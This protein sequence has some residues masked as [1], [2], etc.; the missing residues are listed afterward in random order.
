MNEIDLDLIDD[1][2][3]K[4]DI[5]KT[6]IVMELLRMPVGKRVG[7]WLSDYHANVFN[8]SFRCDNPQV[9]CDAAGMP[10]F[11]LQVPEEGVSFESYSIASIT[12]HLLDNGFGVVINK[13]ENGAAWCFSY[14]EIWSRK[15]TG[16][17][18]LQVPESDESEKG[19]KIMMAGDPGENYLPKRVRKSIRS[20]LE[21]IGVPDPSVTLIF[22]EGMKSPD[23]IF[24]L[25]RDGFQSQNEFDFAFR[26]LRWYLPNHYSVISILSSS[27]LVSQLKPL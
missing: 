8:A 21:R 25:Y 7:D 4:P 13:N 11:S 10:F 27:G 1:S 3:N 23:L 9:I 22:Q 17:F 20:Y 5:A 6:A 15:M 2:I 16:S 24:S 12:E 14:G 18:V 19:G 26:M